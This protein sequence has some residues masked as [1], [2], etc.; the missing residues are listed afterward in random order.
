METMSTR[1][2]VFCPIKTLGVHYNDFSKHDTCVELIPF[3]F[4]LLQSHECPRRN[5]YQLSGLVW[6]EEKTQK[7]A[8]GKVKVFICQQLYKFFL[9]KRKGFQ[10]T[11]KSLG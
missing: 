7:T 1:K 11:I 6:K 9:E 2:Y 10:K 3:C 5:E 8:P 4:A